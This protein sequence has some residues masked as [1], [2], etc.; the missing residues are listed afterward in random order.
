MLKLVRIRETSMRFVISMVAVAMI[1]S[2][3][4]AQAFREPALERL[5]SDARGRAEVR[6]H[7]AT[8]TPRFI[9]FAEG[10]LAE[11]AA[12][13]VQRQVTSFVNNY[14]AAFGVDPGEL[15]EISRIRED[16][17]SVHVSFAQSYRGVPV[18]AG[19]LRL[20]MDSA[21]RAMAVNGTTIPDLAIDPEPRLASRAAER[22]AL[23]LASKG[24]TATPTV[25]KSTL[26]IYRTG[27]ARGVVGE[28]HLAWEV[29]VVD[30]E[31][32]RNFYYIDAHDGAFIDQM[33][34][35]HEAVP[36]RQLFEKKM[37]PSTLV[38]K[39]GD[40]YPTGNADHDRIID[41]TGQTFRFFMNAFGRV[42]YDGK[43][44]VMNV[45]NNDERIACPN[46]TWD[47]KTANFCDGT[48]ADDVIAHEWVHGYTQFAHGLIYLW[49]PGALNES[50]SD[51]FGET[52][53]LLNGGGDEHP[54]PVR[55]ADSCTL[56]S[57]LSPKVNIDEPGE[58]AR[59]F[60]AMR[61][62]FG[63]QLTL[64]GVRGEIV[65]VDDGK[66]SGETGT[67][68]DGCEGSF[69]TDVRGKIALIDRGLCNF[70]VKVKNA[71]VN[72]AVGVV[73]ANDLARGDGLFVMGGEDDTITIPSLFV[74]YS[75]GAAIRD[76]LGARTEG[77]LRLG[78]EGERNARW[79]IGESATG[80]GRAIRDMW[81]PG[82]FKRARAV[83]EENYYCGGADN[84]G[85]HLN[86]SVPNFTYALLVDGGAHNGEEVAPIGLIKAAHI[87]YRAMS[88]YQVPDSDFSDHADA[89]E[90]SC[91]DLIGRAL[92]HPLT[93]DAS[94]EVI[95]AGD[96]DQV[97]NAMRATEMRTPPSQC[98]YKPLLA[99]EA[100]AACGGTTLFSEDFENGL[101]AF[102]TS[103]AGA[104]ETWTP[105]QWVAMSA[106]P[107]GRSGGVA[108]ATDR[109]AVDCSTSSEAGL[110]HLETP[111]ITLPAD[112]RGAMTLSFDHYVATEFAYDGGNVWVSVN[113]APYIALP[114]TAFSY[115]SY[116][117]KLLPEFRGNSNPIAGEDTFSGMDEGV[118]HGS[119]GRSLADLAKVARPG[120]KIRL[121]FTLG[122]DRCVG[123]DGWYVDD[124]KITVCDAGGARRRP[125]RP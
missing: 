119:W 105:R 94:G 52:I 39:E 124:V 40:A 60:K 122:T 75:S 45:I 69:I 107:G 62:E 61:A 101:G 36:T 49:Q 21:G 96:C 9:R 19:V 125:V 103:G 32:G 113:G 100:P 56:F 80:F 16:E 86:S 89:I 54:A 28:N 12:A 53:D 4:S 34:G 30:D 43:G 22:T 23:V 116:T 87:Y 115:N 120:D 26:Y 93:G 71:Q 8:G 83:S 51:I 15:S 20:H 104:L 84:G 82:C 111:E 27:L 31:G 48:A 74:G 46:A 55:S 42:S 123:R 41:A 67:R 73:V 112:A 13:S 77:S 117:Q 24:T 6:L 50:Y 5:V 1:A 108:Y 17:G 59:S 57:D 63:P 72:G 44:A 66:A 65:Y 35:I 99:K 121:R 85:V 88:T 95:S 18:F 78:G 10:F 2:P 92:A 68:T 14:A 70:T 102:T 98:K 91:V 118:L 64:D 29:E 7:R 114:R 97:K 76:G 106:A 81:N 25:A 3:A 109:A 33:S 11:P 47:G 38:W 37:A 110:I 79:L 58:L 90:T